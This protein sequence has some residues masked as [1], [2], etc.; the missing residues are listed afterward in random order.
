[1]TTVGA[2]GI[3]GTGAVGQA[4]ACALVS[5]GFARRLMLLS[6]TADQAAACA[7]DV[8]DLGATLGSPARVCAVDTVGELHECDAIVIAVRAAFVS[9]PGVDM[10]H[11]GLWDNAE[12]VHRLGFGLRGYPGVVLMVTNPVDIMSRLMAA[13]SGC[14]VYGVGAG[15]DSARYRALLGAAYGVPHR[16][17]E[18]YVIGEHGDAAVCCLS[19]TRIDGHP[20]DADD[21]RTHAALAAFAQRSLVIM[22]GVGRVRAG[23]AGAVLSALRATVGALEATEPLST[24]YGEHGWLG[25][26]VTFT[27]HRSQPGLP[28]LT[29]PEQR[30][31]DAADHKLRTRYTTVQTYLSTMYSEEIAQ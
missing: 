22:A 23:A 26:P 28:A 29:E 25:Q 20:V 19:T 18:G 11:A 21:P 30:Q 1:V 16:Q 17:V 5:A 3:V 7:A 31:L 10:R 24:R 13:T 15:L 8:Q 27:R 4:V 9:R 6:R 2:V 14:Q 12:V